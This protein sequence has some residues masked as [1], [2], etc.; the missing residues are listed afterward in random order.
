MF[1]PFSPID[2]TTGTSVVF[3]G[4]LTC[5]HCLKDRVEISRKQFKV[6]ELR[7]GVKHRPSNDIM[8]FKEAFFF[9]YQRSPSKGNLRLECPSLQQSH[10]NDKEDSLSLASEREFCKWIHRDSMCE[11]KVWQMF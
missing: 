4:M 9:F 11:E 8:V 1:T 7:D 5:F 6:Y 3:Q 10:Q 2:E